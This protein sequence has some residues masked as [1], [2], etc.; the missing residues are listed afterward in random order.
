MGAPQDGKPLFRTGSAAHGKLGVCTMGIGTR[1]GKSK[2]VG[3]GSRMLKV[4]CPVGGCAG[5]TDP[6]IARVAR[7]WLEAPGA[8]LCPAHNVALVQA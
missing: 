2:G 5:G 8:P 7:S 3:S 1:G 6:Y 4:A